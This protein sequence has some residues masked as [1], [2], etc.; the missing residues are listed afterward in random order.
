MPSSA[1]YRPTRRVEGKP[2]VF[3]TRRLLPETE[4]R[5]AELFDVVL[6]SDDRPLG[7]AEL[8][9]AMQDAHVLVP[10]VTDRIDASMIA[11][12]KSVV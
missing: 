5:M 8:V 6:N 7:R 12:R 4:A 11:D 9:A 1:D 10:T 3:V 2:R